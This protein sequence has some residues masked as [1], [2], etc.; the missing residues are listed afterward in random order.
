MPWLKNHAASARVVAVIMLGG[1]GLSACASTSY[2]DEKIAA[3]NSRIDQVDGRV[4][5][6][7]QRAEAANT[8]AQAAASSAQA[9]NQAAQAAATDARTANQRLDQ[10]GGRVDALEKPAARRTPRG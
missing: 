10:L 6:A 7:A 1:L 5:T 9:A 8:A 3:V 2:V 4:Q